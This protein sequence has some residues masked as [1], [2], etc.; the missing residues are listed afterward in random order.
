MYVSRDGFYDVIDTLIPHEQRRSSKVLRFACRKL[1][2]YGSPRYLQHPS[3]TELQTT[4][5]INEKEPGVFSGNAAD[6]VTS[7]RGNP[8]SMVSIIPR[9]KGLGY[10]QY[11]PKEQYLYTQE[12]LLDRMCM[13]LGGRVSEQIFFKKITTGAQDDLRKVTQTAYSQVVMFGMNEKVG[14]LSFDMNQQ[15]E[16]AFTKPY[17]EATAQLI[18]EEVRQ[19]VNNAYQRTMDLLNKHKDHV[20][21]VALRLLEKEKLD[22]DDMVEL[23]GKRPFAEKSTYEEFVAGTGSFEEDTTLPK[24]LENWNKEK[25]KKDPEAIES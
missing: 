4:N 15:G 19:I 22:K 10:A 16:M 5:F 13:M 6:V 9:G 12:Q 21:K 2:K 1:I 11:L 14:Q 20:E 23:L 24:G 7:Q 3:L 8:S 17:S 18:D 25:E